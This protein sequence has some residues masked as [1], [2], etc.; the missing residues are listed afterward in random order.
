VVRKTAENPAK[1]RL[2]RETIVDSA[3]A[4]ADAE[5]LDAVTIRRLAQDQGVTP[6]ALYWH[7]RDKDLLL[8][9]ISERVLSEVVL[10]G[11]QDAADAPWDERL[12]ELLSALLDV[13]RAHPAIAD[14]VRTRILGCL[15]GLE[16]SER[17]FGLLRE[18]G[19]DAD[20]TAQIGIQALHTLVML[21][22]GEPG[23]RIGN[24]A[25]E[26]VRQRMRTKKA[27]LQ[28]LSP[29]H[30]PNVLDCADGMTGAPPG[31]AYYG[32]GLSLLIEGIRGVAPATPL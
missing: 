26:A 13:L 28:T 1:E 12:R 6:M 17:A 11:P 9:G 15:P 2:T 4:L 7:F 31:S 22:T 8:D 5:G 25:D 27:A 3:M 16:L 29:D 24:E 10:P 19:F 14:L 21:V 18:A 23:Q 32:L 20:Q 30:Y